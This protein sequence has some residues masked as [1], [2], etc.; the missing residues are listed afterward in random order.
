M[1]ACQ[2]TGD[3]APVTLVRQAGDS[4]GGTVIVQKG[5]TL[6]GIA[7][8]YDVPLR[9]LIEVNRASPPY[10]L[11]VG[12]RLTLP[13]TRVYT[14][15]RGD[16]L[17]GISRMTGVG[18]NELSRLNG[19]QEPYAVQS[20]Q[21][22]RLPPERG[23][24]EV[25]RDW[26]PPPAGAPGVKP[27][28]VVTAAAPPPPPRSEPIALA[29]A[30]AA[31]PP[32]AGTA[33]SPKVTATPL[34]PPTAAP[35]AP[36]A[37]A[38]P[39]P[40]TAAAPA[41]APAAAPPPAAPPATAKPAPAAPAQVAAAPPPRPPSEE[42]PPPRGGSRFL[43]PVKGTVVSTFGT[44]TDGMHNDGINIAA[45]KGTP[46]V[47]A[48][49][50]VVVYAGNE[51]RGFGNLLLVRHADG[52]ISAYAH[53]DRMDVQRGATVRR[54]QAIGTVGQTGSV[55]TPQLHFELRKGSQAIDPRTELEGARVSEGASPAGRP[56][57]G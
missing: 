10:A 8:R 55:S 35:A 25:A 27:A 16:T 40:A 23:G 29:P 11:Q 22:L 21:Q 1:A 53:L 56:G 19:L 43:W 18:M 12:E 33:A 28:P 15:Q 36:P 37:A 31:A 14:V 9:D 54:G 51:L 42:G 4:V 50:G 41:P 13:R 47:A 20:G 24:V 48:D 6:Y 3:P 52:F 17:H 2:R 38:S 34:P 46:V 45:P 49:N 7:R 32:P 30:P 57:P 5:D 39:P 44:K 26:S